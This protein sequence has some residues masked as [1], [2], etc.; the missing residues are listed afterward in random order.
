MKKNVKNNIQIYEIPRK[1]YILKENFSVDNNCLTQKL[2]MKR[3]I[4]EEKYRNI[5]ESL[6]L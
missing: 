2:T 5:I 3:N 4:I 1:V 6:Y